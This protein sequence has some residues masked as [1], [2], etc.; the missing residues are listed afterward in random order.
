METKRIFRHRGGVVLGSMWGGGRGYY[1]ASMIEGEFEREEEVTKAAQPL[2][3]SG[4]LDSG[5]GFESLLGAVI[6]IEEVERTIGG[7]EKS[8]GY[9]FVPVVP[10]ALAYTDEG[11]KL[12]SEMLDYCQEDGF[13]YF[14]STVK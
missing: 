5:M 14:N 7:H 3:E 13:S 9:D 6:A 8:I 2:L 11:S 1:P 10:E 12:A 4:A